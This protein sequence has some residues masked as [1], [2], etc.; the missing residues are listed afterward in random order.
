MALAR[1]PVL[2]VAE[3]GISLPPRPYR[4]P[5][6]SAYGMASILG[7]ICSVVLCACTASVSAQEALPALSE[8]R[9]ILSLVTMLQKAVLAQVPG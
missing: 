4:K 6:G 8:L 9:S 7:F 2:G 3:A 1:P 5:A